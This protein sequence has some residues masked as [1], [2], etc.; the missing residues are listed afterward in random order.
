MGPG[1]LVGPG[2]NERGSGAVLVPEAAKGP[3]NKGCRGLGDVAV[4]DGGSCGC[5]CCCRCCVQS[6]LEVMVCRGLAATALL[7]DDVSLG[8]ALWW[9]LLL[10]LQQQLLPWRWRPEPSNNYIYM[11]VY[12]IYTCHSST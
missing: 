5:C 3:R 4:G 2:P 12:I 8:G 1:A 11:C 10:L 9:S 7:L 6:G